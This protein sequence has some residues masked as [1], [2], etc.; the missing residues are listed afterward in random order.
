MK[1][2]ERRDV[3]KAEKE[4]KGGGGEEYMEREE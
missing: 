1:Q 2:E 3:G 4:K